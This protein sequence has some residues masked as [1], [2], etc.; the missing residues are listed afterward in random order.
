MNLDK[1]KKEIS[2][3]IRTL[4]H[5]RKITQEE[6]AKLLGLSQAHLSK[7]ERGQGSLSAEQLVWL[8]QNYNLPLAY[9]ISS[10]ETNE[11]R[12]APLQN[13]LAHLGADHLREVNGTL[14]PETLTNPETT[15]AQTL[16]TSPSPRLITALAPVIVKNCESIHF[17]RLAE[18]FKSRGA[19]NRWGWA[20]E[21]TYKALEERL[22]EA[23]LPRQLHRL[24]QK[25][26]LLLERKKPAPPAEQDLSKEDELDGGLI[27][28]RT[29]DLVKQGRDKWAR[30]WGIITRIKKEDFLK[31]LKDSE[32]R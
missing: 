30:R 1:I 7:I 32:E 18:T 26:F 17:D 2:H 23:Y 4:R 11:D 15:I 16:L 19:E 5:D 20:L 29:L 10:K 14:V 13:A 27:S 8:Q 25:A 3:G 9:F 6:L 21:L 12:E 24:Y 28:Q 31:A 22:Q